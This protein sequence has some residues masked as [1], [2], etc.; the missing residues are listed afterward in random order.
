M[1]LFSGLM[2]INAFALFVI[3]H[4]I[5]GI[6]IP[7]WE[8]LAAAAIVLTFVNFFLKPILKMIMLPVNILTLGFFTLFINAA[9]LWMVSG[10]VKGF[11]IS[12]FGSALSG[13]ILLSIIY[14]IIEKFIIADR[15]LFKPSVDDYDDDDENSDTQNIIDVEGKFE[16]KDNNKNDYL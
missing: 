10:M 16:D 2:L 7:D 3:S 15:L 13:A 14:L 9:L 4:I 8:T 11:Y 12:G 6:I 5:R 1:R